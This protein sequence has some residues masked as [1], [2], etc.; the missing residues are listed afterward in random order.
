MLSVAATEIDMGP[1]FVRNLSKPFLPGF[2]HEVLKKRI[3]TGRIAPDM[4]VRGPTT[5]QLWVKARH[6]PGLA[7]LLGFCHACGAQVKP[8]DTGCKSCS[9]PFAGS[10]SRNE[11]G[12]RFP[13]P[14]AAAKARVDLNKAI[15]QAAEQAKARVAATRAEDAEDRTEQTK[16]EDTSAQ[17]GAA[18]LITDGWS[19][20]RAPAE[21]VPPLVSADQS[22][23]SDTASADDAEATLA[24]GKLTFATQ[25]VVQGLPNAMAGSLVAPGE[26]AITIR[27]SPDALADRPAGVPRLISAAGWFWLIAIGGL[28]FLMFRHVIMTMG[29]VATHRF[30]GDWSHALVVPLIAVYFIHQR[31]EKLAETQ[32]RVCW[33]GLALFFVGI[34][35]YVWWIYPGR[36][37]MLQ[38][39]SMLVSLF[40]LALFLLGPAMMRWLW[41]PIAYLV[42]AVKVSDRIWFKLAAAL[43]SLAAKA[44]TLVLQFF[45]VFTDLETRLRG[46]TIELSFDRQGAW[47]T[48][49]LN[50]AEACSG[51]RMLAAFVA[52]GVL[53]AFVAQR[54]WWQRLVMVTLT[55][56]IA[57]LV[58][59][60][61]VTVLGLLLPI[62]VELVSGDF[63][64]YVGL[65]MLIPAL[66]LFLLV[67][68]VLDRI[69][70]YDDQAEPDAA[71][72]RTPTPKPLPVAITPMER[73]NR[74][75]KGLLVGGGFCLLV[76]LTYG[77]LLLTLRPD[78][79]GEQFAAPHAM[80]LLVVSAAVTLFAMWL[81]ARMIRPEIHEPHI[82]GRTVSMAL[83]A[84]VLCVAVLG[85][86]YVVRATKAVLI[87]QPV[88]LRQQLYTLPV[89][90]G[91][92]QQVGRDTQ[93]TPEVLETLGTNTYLSRQY[94]DTSLSADAPGRLVK[95]H[96]AYYTGTPDTV[97]HVP[98]R[99][100]V[101]GGMQAVDD[102]TAS[103]T[104]TGPKYEAADT[105]WRAESLLA[106]GDVRLPDRHIRATVFTFCLP[107]D[108]DR[109]SNVVYFFSANGRFY[110]TPEQVRLRGFDPTDRH[111]YYCK[112]EVMLPNVADPT[113]AGERASAFLSQVM[114]EIM[115]CLPD[116]F[117]VEAGDWPP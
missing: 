94:E 21:P 34:F 73:I 72:R 8:T 39:Y 28:F 63:H 65:M 104:L 1:W 80:Q 83:V 79:G 53:V 55:V 7:H 88:P 82:V 78:L 111:S 37:D 108:P 11:L 36:N 59:I 3:E 110:R 51:L 2:S 101:A 29:R 95:L 22:G 60:G 117:D 96:V 52:L 19:W 57:V 70:I 112:I 113:V 116:W 18:D 5:R 6:A 98:E 105:G 13:T 41:L 102:S 67:G 64:K 12:L 56:P 40:G 97:P 84:G 87:K 74:V 23:E 43:Q 69:Y 27:H 75:S 54:A 20:V 50:V 10:M 42:L 77:F 24:Q 48:E 58:N 115:A 17:A 16:A 33:Q 45:G 76:G 92:W 91:A 14:Y 81:I 30:G 47:V 46:T 9:A 25:T 85:M 31:R 32:P 114:P 100:F 44:A 107:N 109:Q 68:W 71:S 38:G 35:S 4:I 86:T 90:I 62:D 99:C 89:R 103:L 106:R 93:M 61:R 49:Q 26:D 15:L 66:L